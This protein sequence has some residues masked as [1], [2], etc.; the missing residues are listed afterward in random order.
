MA[1]ALDIPTTAASADITQMVSGKLLELEWEPQNVQVLVG[2]ESTDATD[3]SLVLQGDSGVFVT[4]PPVTRDLLENH[5][6]E[7]REHVLSAG[8]T[9]T[10]QSDTLEDD[11]HRS[12]S[13]HSVTLEQQLE[14]ELQAVKNEL[15]ATEIALNQ[16]RKTVE[17]LHEEQRT[18]L[19]EVI[20][21]SPRCIT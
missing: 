12:T 1:Q 13:S 7:A 18:T 15:Q 3:V 19:E 2:L 5:V 20:K 21:Q 10:I 9:G 14:V 16:E 17:K 6:S 8:S 4:V 11:A